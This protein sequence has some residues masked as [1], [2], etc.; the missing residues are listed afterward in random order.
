MLLQKKWAEMGQT[1]PV[2]TDATLHFVYHAWILETRRI[3]VNYGRM[4]DK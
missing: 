1:L 2:Q 4:L 3:I